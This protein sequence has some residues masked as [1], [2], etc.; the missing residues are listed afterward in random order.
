MR[1][2][3]TAIVSPAVYPRFVEIAELARSLC[4]SCGRLL[5]NILH[6]GALAL[7]PER[8]SARMSKIKND[9][10][11]QYGKLYSLNGV[12]TERVKR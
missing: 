5:V 12:D 9:G 8:H 2:L 7:S 3:K 6:S 4:H 11:D 10:L 1:I